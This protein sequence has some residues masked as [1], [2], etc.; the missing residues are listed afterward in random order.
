MK[1]CYKCKS[2]KLQETTAEDRIKV[3]GK[4]FTAMVPVIKCRACGELYYPGPA[5]EAFELDVAGE[6]ARHG[7]ASAEA[8][9]FMRRALG[10]KA[11]ELAE[12]LDVTPETVSRWEHGRQPIDRGA[13]ALLS[14]MVVDRLEGRTT[15]L[16]RLKTL[17]KPEP[18]P[19]LVRLVPR[20]A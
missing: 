20:H 12:L 5:L 6:L 2:E 18:L 16:D 8:F 3:A 1:R 17:L 9:S 11:V 15:A 7:E 14:T 19:R 4:T 10:V 13:A